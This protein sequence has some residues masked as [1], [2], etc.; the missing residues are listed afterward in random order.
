MTLGD[1]LQAG[2]LAYDRVAVAPDVY[3]LDDDLVA[4]VR[5]G[6]E[7]PPQLE[8]AAAHGADMCPVMAVIV[9][10]RT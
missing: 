3:D 5:T 1:V 6:A 9:V 2:Q 4:V 7:I 8:E 10:D